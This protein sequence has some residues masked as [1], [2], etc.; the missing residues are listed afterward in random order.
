MDNLSLYVSYYQDNESYDFRIP[1][2]NH[3]ATGDK[4]IAIYRGIYQPNTELNN[5]DYPIVKRIGNVNLTDRTFKKYA[6]FPQKVIIE[7]GDSVTISYNEKLRLITPLLTENGFTPEFINEVIN[8]VLTKS[9]DANMKVDT[10]A[11][12]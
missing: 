4:S 5:R 10:D 6:K 9:E 1:E 3:V 11:V 7:E 2:Y 8:A 12:F